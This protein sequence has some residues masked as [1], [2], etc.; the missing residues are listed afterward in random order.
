MVVFKECANQ[1][2]GPQRA[3]TM[4]RAQR[5]RHPTQWSLSR[6]LCLILTNE[7]FYHEWR[8]SIVGQ[9]AGDAERRESLRPRSTN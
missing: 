8:D 7:S 9:Q 6:P 2:S 4:A 5:R 3:R 1:A